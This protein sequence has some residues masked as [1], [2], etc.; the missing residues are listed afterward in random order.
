MS[1]RKQKHINTKD[2]NN[3]WHLSSEEATLSQKPHYNG[4]A[5]G[6]GVQG[7]TKYNRRKEKEKFLKALSDEE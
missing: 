6:H 7:D 3:V 2:K 5:I 4:F 1:K